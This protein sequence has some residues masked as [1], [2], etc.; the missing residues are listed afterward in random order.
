MTFW[1]ESSQT[2]R[3][4]LEKFGWAK[5]FPNF[6][7]DLSWSLS[8]SIC[9][10]KFISASMTRIR[11]SGWCRWGSSSRMP[12]GF[13]SKNSR[14]ALWNYSLTHWPPKIRRFPLWSLKLWA[15]FIKSL[16]TSSWRINRTVIDF[17]EVWLSWHNA[18]IKKY[19]ITSF[20]IFLVFF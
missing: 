12:P 16:L 19:L 18:K 3:W 20:T 13:P 4:R 17:G 10:K 11:K 9:R 1:R 5:Y 14:L 15:R 8:N 6:Y 7:R 2:I